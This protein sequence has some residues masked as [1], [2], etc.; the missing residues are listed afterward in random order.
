MLLVDTGESVTTDGVAEDTAL[1]VVVVD[2]D[3]DKTVML[4]RP[5]SETFLDL[6]SA[7]EDDAAGVKVDDAADDDPADVAA[8]A[9]LADLE[10]AN[11]DA[12]GVAKGVLTLTT[13]EAVAD[14]VDPAEVAEG[15]GNVVNVGFDKLD[16][17]NTLALRL[18]GG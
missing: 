7:G 1:V 16:R 17:L 9:A 8:P 2:V 12:E 10:A 13:G 14:P 3:L 5:A 4:D 18:I 15:A 11:T 6:A